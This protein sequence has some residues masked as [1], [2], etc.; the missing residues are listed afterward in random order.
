MHRPGVELA[1]IRSQVRLP[2]HYTTEPPRLTVEI[3]SGGSTGGGSGI[4]EKEVQ[5][6]KTPK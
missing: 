4:Y 6:V 3:D 2:N 1:T 5:N